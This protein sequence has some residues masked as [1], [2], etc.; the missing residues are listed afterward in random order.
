MIPG[1]DK[2]SSILSITCELTGSSMLAPIFRKAKGA[3]MPCLLN[4]TTWSGSCEQQWL[5]RMRKLSSTW[6][7]SKIVFCLVSYWYFPSILEILDGAATYE[8][9]FAPSMSI[10]MIWDLSND[11]WLNFWPFCRA[12]RLLWVDSTACSEDVE[13]YHH[14][15]T[16]YYLTYLKWARPR[17]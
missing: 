5:T 15:A 11:I 2:Y 1:A 6:I 14:S 7:S 17:G 13:Y 10:C 8:L 4:A 12:R 9:L 16:H 3:S